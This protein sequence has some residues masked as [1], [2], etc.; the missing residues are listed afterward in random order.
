MNGRSTRGWST[1]SRNSQ[2]RS[3]K[4]RNTKRRCAYER[5]SAKRRS[6]KRRSAKRRSAKGC[7]EGARYLHERP[8]EQSLQHRAK[9]GSIVSKIAAL[10]LFMTA[11]SKTSV[12]TTGQQ[13]STGRRYAVRAYGMGV[14]VTYCTISSPPYAITVQLRHEHTSPPLPLAPASP[15][16]PPHTLAQYRTG[17]CPYASAVPHQY[18]SS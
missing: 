14:R 1:K 3:A 7:K 13:A 15:P 8:R 4:G 2:G 18:A 6:A 11:L 17:T 10:P 9:N 12:N 16:Y 5:R